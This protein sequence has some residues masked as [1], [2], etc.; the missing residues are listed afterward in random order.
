MS[1]GTMTAALA[2]ELAN[3]EDMRRLPPEPPPVPAP[4]VFVN[5]TY[6]GFRGAFYVLHKR[7]PTEQEIFDAGVRSGL[8]RERMMVAAALA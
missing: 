5:H 1:H 8:E 6:G 4:M 3:S 7:M 2:Q